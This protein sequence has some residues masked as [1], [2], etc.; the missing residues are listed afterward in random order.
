MT[1]K[2]KCGENCVSM[3]QEVELLVPVSRVY[4][5]WHR[6]G[7]MAED[8]KKQDGEHRIVDSTYTVC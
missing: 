5:H 1:M 3:K 6:V 2:S 8:V 7:E 4:L